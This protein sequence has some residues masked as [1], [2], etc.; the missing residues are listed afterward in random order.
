MTRSKRSLHELI[1][2]F[3]SD[4]SPTGERSRILTEEFQWASS[5]PETKGRQEQNCRTEKKFKNWR[6]DVCQN[7]QPPSTNPKEC[8][9]ADRRERADSHSEQ[10]PLGNSESETR[11]YYVR[12]DDRR[13]YIRNLLWSSRVSYTRSCE[14]VPSAPYK[15]RDRQV[16]RPRICTTSHFLCHRV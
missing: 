15:P 12:E 1:L 9:E 6:L 3:D 8:R 10:K 11:I 16:A 13:H 14:P 2:V 7:W 5:W 4:A